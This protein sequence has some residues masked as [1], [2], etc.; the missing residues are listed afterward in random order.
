MTI[1]DIYNTLVQLNF[2]AILD[3]AQPPK[4]MPGQTIKF[5]KGRKN[6][7]ARKHLQRTQTHDDDKAKGPFVPPSTYKVRWDADRVDEYLARWE[8]KGYMTLKPEKL[9]WS[10]FIL[11][12]AMKSQSTEG[13]LALA[14]KVGDPSRSTSTD[15]LAP[16]KAVSVTTG[17]DGI[18]EADTSTDT[19]TPAFDL[20]DNDN[21]EV[22][23]SR[24]PRR[25]A[26][27]ETSESRARSPSA[28]VF[29]PK[30][31]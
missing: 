14:A 5:P 7:I 31:G 3:S 24:A 30:A 27:S 29:E 8:A 18:A 25:P 13:E 16:D 11:S 9:K 19:H 4:P 21:V 2:L 15:I 1:E 17:M 20:F 22:V 10:P 28:E 23:R 26:A 12:R 6:G